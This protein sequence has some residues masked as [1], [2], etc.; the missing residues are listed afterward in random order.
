MP[1]RQ[2]KYIV[3]IVHRPILVLV[4]LCATTAVAQ[5]R[6]VRL[7]PANPTTLTPVS[8]VITALQRCESLP[9]LLVDRSGYVIRIDI[10]PTCAPIT[11]LEEVIVVPFGHL[12]AGIYEYS[13]H[14]N[15]NLAYSDNFV[16]ADAGS[17][18]NIPTLSPAFLALLALFIASIGVLHAIRSP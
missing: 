5:V 14:I 2:L 8:I 4:F 1:Q 13:I 6:N 12:P 11:P 10:P 9:P 15:N 17:P 3:G 18:F 7:E 16:V